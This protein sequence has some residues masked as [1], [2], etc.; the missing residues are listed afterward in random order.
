MSTFPVSSRSRIAVCALSA[1]MLLCGPAFAIDASKG[2]YRIPYANGTEVKVSNDHIDHSPPGRIDMG[3]RGGGPYRIVAAADGF[4]RHVVDGFDDRLDCKGK[5][6]SE[7]KNNYVWIEH[8]NGEWTK[9]THM[10]KGSSSGKAGLREGLFVVK[11]QG[12]PGG[13][14]RHAVNQRDH[15][16]RILRAHGRAVAEH[17]G[18]HG[19]EFAE[20]GGVCGDDG[21][22]GRG[23][24]HGVFLRWAPVSPAPRNPVR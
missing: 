14:Q 11:R 16:A 17:R 23:D 18:C 4:V 24:D 3:G 12:R 10:Q 20:H 9:Y 19:V 22:W 1:S 5:P 8:P 6:V 7:Q 21:G 15:G 13:R 2:V